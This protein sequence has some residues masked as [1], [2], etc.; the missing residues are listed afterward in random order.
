MWNRGK[1]K[2]GSTRVSHAGFSF[3]SKLEAAVYDMLKE[4]EL[5]GEIKIEQM[6]A[7]VKLTK[8]EII[9]KPDFKCSYTASGIDFFVEAKGLETDVWRIKRRLWIHYGPSSLYVYKGSHKRL[10]LHE[11]LEPKQEGEEK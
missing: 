6:Q 1:N 4:R 10:R 2:Y 5:A 7:Q 9:Y 11:V 3:A 8:A